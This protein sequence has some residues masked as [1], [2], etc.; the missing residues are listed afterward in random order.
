MM[1]GHIHVL[2]AER[3]QR[4]RLQQKSDTD[5]FMTNAIP[6]VSY[7]FHHQSLS[8]HSGMAPLVQALG[9]HPIYY[10]VVWEKI[11][12]R[13]WRIGQWVRKSGQIWSGSEWFAPLPWI[14]ERR[15][16]RALPR[17]CSSIAHYVFADFTPPVLIDQVHQRGG[18][19][20]ATFHV[21]ARR[22][23]KVLAGV[24]RL[25]EIDAVT[26]VSESQRQWFI[27]RGVPEERIHVILHGV[28]T[29]FFRPPDIRECQN[30]LRLLIVGKTER[31]HEFAADVMKRLPRGTAELRV[32]TSREQQVHYHGVQ[33][34]VILDHRNDKELLREYQQADLLFMP[35]LDCTANNAVL[36]SMACGTPVM[37]NRVGG[38]P[39]YVDTSCNM[40]MDSKNV[41]EWVDQ[42]LTITRDR[43]SLEAWR[44]VVR[45]WAE[46]FDWSLIAKQYK[47][48]F[49]QLA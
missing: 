7:L 45:I 10:N 38:I 18:Q 1:D 49:S 17:G 14:D 39:E 30:K 3:P 40:V 35:M 20:V 11:Q 43:G 25:N 5:N 8:S 16:V 6:V 47:A 22:A 12:K 41:D 36:E 19:I 21:T 44:P 31:D 23:S 2:S 27:E 34:V 26:L 42:I 4:G 9:S 15:L 33:N 13:S 28:V 37:T 46:G 29:D 24:K 48:L 32:M